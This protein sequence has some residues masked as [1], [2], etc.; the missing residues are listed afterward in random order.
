MITEINPA[1]A[2]PYRCGKRRLLITMDVTTWETRL[3]GGVKYPGEG[4]IF[5]SEDGGVNWSEFY[6]LGFIGDRCGRFWA[7]VLNPAHSIPRMVSGTG[8][9]VT[10]AKNTYELVTD[11]QVNFANVTRFTTNDRI[12]V[13]D[14]DAYE[15]IRRIYA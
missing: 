2:H 7:L 6:L 12:R 5:F 8:G 14:S 11:E 9:K 3:D 13:G 15:A 1:L 10:F 4:C